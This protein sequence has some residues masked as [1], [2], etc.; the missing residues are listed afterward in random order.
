MKILSEFKTFAVKGNMFDMA[1]G[2]VIGAAFGKVVDSLVK[3][4]INPPLGYL[5]G[6]VDFRS[7]QVVLIDQVKEGDKII[8]PEVAIKYGKFL[9]TFLDFGIIAISIFLV[10]KTINVLKE[11][12]EDINNLEIPTPKNIEMLNDIRDALKRKD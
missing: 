5:I 9:S 11:K 2:V 8:Q 7:L 6:K 3:D 1:I 10:I 4:I 12:A